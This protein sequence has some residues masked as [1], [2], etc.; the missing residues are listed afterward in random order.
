MVQ[1]FGAMTALV[2]PFKKNGEVD[3]NRYRQLIDRQIKG[4]IHWIVPV[5]TT[6]ESPTL[7]YEEHKKCIQIAVEMCQNTPTRVLA[8]TGS[9]STR[10]AIELSKFAG[11]V[12]V[13][14]VLVVVPYYNKPTQEGL[15]RH[16]REIARQIP[17]VPIV[18]YNIPGRS[19][20]QLKVETVVKLAK[21]FPNIRGIKEATGN[22]ENLVALRKELPNFAIL[23]GD[24]S[25]NYPI[26]ASGGQGVISVVSNLFPGKVAEMVEKALQGDLEGAWKLNSE[27]YDWSKILFLESNPIPV[28]YVMAKMGLLE[29]SYRLPLCEPTLETQRKI[30][31]FLRER[32]IL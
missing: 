16:F 13:E 15:Y 23:S 4:G 12:G 26:L 11:K 24:D 21:E 29:L 1:I 25:I 7:S 32:G 28:K 8:G 2:T 9:N 22:I 6:G 17:E 3:W 18:L 10:E 31:Q 27:L 19:C 20:V 30:N 5:G 14:G